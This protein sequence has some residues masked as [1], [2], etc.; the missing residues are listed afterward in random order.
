MTIALTEENIGQQVSTSVHGIIRKGW[1]GTIG[2]EVRNAAGDELWISKYEA[3]NIGPGRSFEERLELPAQIGSIVIVDPENTSSELQ[4][5]VRKAENDW[6]S[7][8]GEFTNSYDNETI[9]S[10]CLLYGYKVVD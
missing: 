5:Y 7:G 8:G 1:N 10:K 6:E 4:A 3:E 9:V 2:I